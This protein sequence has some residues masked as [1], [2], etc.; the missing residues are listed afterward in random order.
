MKIQKPV[1]SQT[2]ASLHIPSGPKAEVGKFENKSQ[3]GIRFYILKKSAAI[4]LLKIQKA[5]TPVSADHKKIRD[6]VKQEIARTRSN[7]F[8]A[9]SY[10]SHIKRYQSSST[11]QRNLPAVP[12]Q[13]AHQFSESKP[14]YAAPATN[15]MSPAQGPTGEAHVV[16]AAG[17]HAFAAKIKRELTP[18][19]QNIE[20][21]NPSQ[22]LP[23]LAFVVGS[24][25][26]AH[27]GN[28]AAMNA[29]SEAI[30]G[31]KQLR[32]DH[33][34]NAND[35]IPDRYKDDYNKEFNDT[36]RMALVEMLPDDLSSA[37]LKVE[38]KVPAELDYLSMIQEYQK[39]IDESFKKLDS[40]ATL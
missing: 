1:D 38:Y 33:L 4:N 6:I 27:Y 40:S 39:L 22:V 31:I 35:R 26:S 16:G 30:K 34:S 18:I 20:R 25:S 5:F 10:L 8:D 15:T 12:P 28:S 19:L 21:S 37:F 7:V 17:I 29:G 24:D 14:S 13:V 9:E 36:C 11:G 23:V 2:S 3:L 32:L